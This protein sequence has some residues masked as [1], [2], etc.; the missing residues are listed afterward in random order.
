MSDTGSSSPGCDGKPVWETGVKSA[1]WSR[2]CWGCLGGGEPACPPSPA[3]V[4]AVLGLTCPQ[5]L[6]LMG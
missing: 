2:D 6:G 1:A 3:Q 4:P 5:G